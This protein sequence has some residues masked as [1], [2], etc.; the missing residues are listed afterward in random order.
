MPLRGS[1]ML[2]D[3]RETPLKNMKTASRTMK[4]G[5]RAGGKLQERRE[6][7]FADRKGLEGEFLED[8][9]DNPRQLGVD[10][11]ARLTEIACWAILGRKITEVM[12]SIR[13]TFKN[14]CAAL[15]W[16]VAPHCKKFP[17]APGVLGNLLRTRG[18]IGHLTR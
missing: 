12:D 2:R 15:P 3:G 7:R 13:K 6:N 1:W 18:G 4:S 16:A 9:L 17:K 5:R 8:N 14:Q 11:S 10:N